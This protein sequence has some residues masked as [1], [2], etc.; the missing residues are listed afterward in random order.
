MS[1]RFENVRVEEMPLN[2]RRFAVKRGEKHLRVGAR[3]NAI[4]CRFCV[5]A[6][7]NLEKI[8]DLST[9]LKFSSE[10]ETNDI[11]KRD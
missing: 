7:L 11:F 1:V 5:S 2:I 4:A 6:L 10:I 3:S 9:G 8:Q